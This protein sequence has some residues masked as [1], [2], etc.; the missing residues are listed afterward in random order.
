MSDIK[1]VSVPAAQVVV[2]GGLTGAKGPQG[3]IGPAGPTGPLGPTGPT[4]ATGA[5]GAQ[6]I[7]GQQGATGLVPAYKFDQTPV[8]AP[9]GVRT[10]F[11]L[12]N[13]DAAI[14]GTINVT[15]NGLALTRGGDFTETS[16][17]TITFIAITLTGDIIRLSYRTN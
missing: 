5:Q 10:L 7:Q 15:L 11:T 6:G 17:T 13:A 4:G 3:P 12:P 16:T 8:E 14:A 9:N 1:V 2:S